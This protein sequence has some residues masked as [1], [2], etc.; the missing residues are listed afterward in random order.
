MG[1]VAGNAVADGD[2]ARI[3]VVVTFGGPEVLFGSA[4]TRGAGWARVSEVV[5]H[6][7]RV[8]MSRRVM[9]KG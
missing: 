4:G 7:K 3:S 5:R 6:E 2:G 8:A 1:V 9:Q